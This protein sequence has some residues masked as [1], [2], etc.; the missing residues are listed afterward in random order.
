MNCVYAIFYIE[1][2]FSINREI[3]GNIT[4]HDV[5]SLFIPKF[6]SLIRSDNFIENFFFL[7]QT[8]RYL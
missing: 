3:S 4:M 7:N 8:N 6:I 1:N 5:I 2:F